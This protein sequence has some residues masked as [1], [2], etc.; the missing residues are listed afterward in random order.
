MRS[1]RQAA[2]SGKPSTD[3]SRTAACAT[4]RRSSFA[5]G[6]L[7]SGRRY[8]SS[9]WGN[10]GLFVAALSG[11]TCA[12][13]HSQAGGDV[14]LSPLSP[15]RRGRTMR[16]S[17]GTHGRR[18]ATASRVATSSNRAPLSGTTAV[19]GCNT[20]LRPSPAMVPR[21]A[22]TASGIPRGEVH[23]GNARA[24]GGVAGHAGLFAMAADLAIFSH[25]LHSDTPASPALRCGWIL[26]ATSS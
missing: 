13:P 15:S 2:P 8:S 11:Q 5:D 20:T 3:H 21:I 26:S 4:G 1:C 24:L 16:D 14:Q 12:T 18:G 6:L 7:P 17:G 22:E 23:D 10:R 25:P 19:S 9:L